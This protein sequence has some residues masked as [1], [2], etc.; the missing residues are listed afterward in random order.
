M[1]YCGLPVKIGIYMFHLRRFLPPSANLAFFCL[2][3][4]GGEAIE[5]LSILDPLLVDGPKQGVWG[6]KWYLMKLI[7]I[8]SHDIWS[9]YRGLYVREDE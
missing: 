6:G 5:S 1:A 4:T 2:D 8:I 7:A 3:S 9:C